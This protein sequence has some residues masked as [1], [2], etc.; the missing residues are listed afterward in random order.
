MPALPLIEGC[1]T[2]NSAAQ[3]V[4]RT[5]TTGRMQP[6]WLLRAMEPAVVLPQLCS[7]CAAG[8]ICD[9]VD[10]GEVFSRRRHVSMVEKVFRLCRGLGAPC[11]SIAGRAKNIAS[12]RSDRTQSFLHDIPHDMTM[13][14]VSRCRHDQGNCSGHCRLSTY[15]HCKVHC[16]TYL[17]R[18]QVAYCTSDFE[19]GHMFARLITS[20][21]FEAEPLVGNFS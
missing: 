9:S 2:N 16:K 14:V 11:F 13:V 19:I 10:E 4:P 7:R 17:R 18:L 12:S 3:N 6:L 20:G 5:R 1:A 15:Q 21:R 8:R